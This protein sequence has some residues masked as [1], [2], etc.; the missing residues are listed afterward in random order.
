MNPWNRSCT[1]CE[2]FEFSTTESVGASDV[3]SVSKLEQSIAE[4]WNQ[5]QYRIYRQQ[6]V[7]Y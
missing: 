1:V 3:N 2:R 7:I 5:M 4:V 6:S